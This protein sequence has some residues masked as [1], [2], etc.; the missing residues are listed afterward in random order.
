MRV[1]LRENFTFLREAVGGNATAMMKPLAG[2]ATPARVAGVKHRPVCAMD[3]TPGTLLSVDCSTT[4]DTITV[5]TTAVS[6]CLRS[7]SLD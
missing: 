6:R 7:G 3:H 5:P 2:G 1:S 4:K